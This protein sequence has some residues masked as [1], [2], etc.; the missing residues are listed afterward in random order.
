[1]SLM[2]VSFVTEALSV[3][4]HGACSVP[5]SGWRIC[6]VLRGFLST[7]MCVEYCPRKRMWIVIY[8]HIHMPKIDMF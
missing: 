6:I 4:M 5:L 1:M 8:A 2:K 7:F 3:D